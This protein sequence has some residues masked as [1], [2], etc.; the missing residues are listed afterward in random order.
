MGKF[1]DF[2]T[3]FQLKNALEY[4]VC[5]TVMLVGLSILVIL[6]PISEFPILNIAKLFLTKLVEHYKVVV[7]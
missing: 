5:S 1:C 6:F 7:N 4:K 3:Y 2:L